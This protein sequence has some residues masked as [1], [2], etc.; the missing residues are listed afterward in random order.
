MQHRFFTMET[1][2]ESS[3]SKLLGHVR[4]GF[5]YLFVAL[6]V[7]FSRPTPLLFFL[8]TI[9]V[10]AGE[11]LRIWASGHLVKSVELIDSG[12]YAFT[13]NPLY[14][15]RFLI[16]TGFCFMARSRYFLNWIALALGY[17]VFFG[18]YIPRKLR[19]EGARLQKMHGGA[20]LHYRASV[21]ILFPSFTRYPGK[22]TRWSLA[23]SV[24][25][26]EYLVAT[27]VSVALG[28]FAWK[29]WF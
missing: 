12:P 15:G 4:L 24:G 18:Y 21:P 16:L 7:A 13:Q 27:G 28:L 22:Q 29:T 10:V 1:L 2:L 5:V 17:A 9:L 19:V 25:N 23:R 20:F 6:L 8:G 26:Q 11:V 14:L 3:R